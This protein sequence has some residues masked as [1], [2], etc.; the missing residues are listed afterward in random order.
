MANII[1]IS[2]ELLALREA[3][4]NSLDRE[5]ARSSSIR[6]DNTIPYGIPVVL[7]RGHI[8]SRVDPTKIIVIGEKVFE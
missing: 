6:N 8:I 7:V 5:Y 3:L 4:N 2:N 1:N